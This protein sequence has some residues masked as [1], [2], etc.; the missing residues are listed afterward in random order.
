[1][2]IMRKEGYS[3]KK[4]VISLLLAMTFILS[5]SVNVFAGDYHEPDIAVRDAPEQVISK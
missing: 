5:V 4:T 2:N 3:L 1:M